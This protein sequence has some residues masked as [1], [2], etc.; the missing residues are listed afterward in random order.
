M[1]LYTVAWTQ[2]YVGWDNLNEHATELALA[3]S[4]MAESSAVIDYIMSL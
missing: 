4:D 2:L 1:K 3:N